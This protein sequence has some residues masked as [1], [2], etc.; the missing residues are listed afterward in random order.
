MDQGFPPAEVAGHCQPR[1]NPLVV[2]EK[3]HPKTVRIGRAAPE[4]V[5][6][7]PVFKRLEI[8][9]SFH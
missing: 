8:T 7:I 1:E 9:A 5:V 6:T 4:T 2:G 3:L